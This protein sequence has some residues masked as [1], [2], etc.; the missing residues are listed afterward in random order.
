MDNEHV[1][2]K[3]FQS[4]LIYYRIYRHVSAIL[5]LIARLHTGKRYGNGWKAYYE[6]ET[7][8]GNNIE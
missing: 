5:L 6:Y 1:D 3:E 7:K 4:T 8:Y 2:E